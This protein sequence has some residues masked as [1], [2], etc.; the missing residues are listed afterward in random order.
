MHATVVSRNVVVMD[1]PVDV[2][3]AD[4]SLAE[5]SFTRTVKLGPDELDSRSARRPS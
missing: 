1:S 2:I 5:P 4:S 3:D